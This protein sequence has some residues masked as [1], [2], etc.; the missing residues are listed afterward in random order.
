MQVISQYWF[1]AQQK[2]GLFYLKFSENLMNLALSSKA[3]GNG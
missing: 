1:A 2:Y 3:T